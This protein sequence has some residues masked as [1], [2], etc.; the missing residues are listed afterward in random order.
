MLNTNKKELTIMDVYFE[1]VR[2]YDAALYAISSNMIEGWQP[3]K[4]DILKFKERMEKMH[5]DLAHFWKIEL[6]IQK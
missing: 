6:S 1:S 3:T 4:E 2:A 5:G